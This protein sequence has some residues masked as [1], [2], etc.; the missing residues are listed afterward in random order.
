VDHTIN[1]QGQNAY[2][3]NIIFWVYVSTSKSKY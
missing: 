2:L 3:R 1:S